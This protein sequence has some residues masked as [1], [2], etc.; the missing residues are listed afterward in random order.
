MRV[1]LCCAIGIIGL[2]ATTAW[3]QTGLRSASLPDRT[4]ANPLA[5]PAMGLPS[6]SLPDRTPQNPIPPPRVD[7]FFAGP[8]TY[9]PWVDDRGRPVYFFPSGF[10][11]VSDTFV[12]ATARPVMERLPKGYLNLQMQ[13]GNA[14]VHV[15]G[16]YMGS[17]D[18]FRRIVPGRPLEA[19]AHRVEIRAPL[20]ETK[21]FDVLIPPSQTVTYRTDLEATAS[22]ETPVVAAPGVPKTFYVIP[23]CYAGDKPPRAKLPRG[24]ERSKLRVIPPQPV[25]SVKR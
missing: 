10:G 11:Y 5:V 19:G 1:R 21:T 6:A 24:C 25:F 9:A 7:R 22:R 8:D 14:E 3:A 16:L 23:G 20:H 2:L 12:P 15:D 18:D 17:V 4:P 13:P